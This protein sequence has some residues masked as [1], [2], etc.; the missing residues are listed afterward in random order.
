MSAPKGN[1]FAKGNNGGRPTKYKPEYC[2]Q[3]IEYFDIDAYSKETIE[4]MTEYFKDGEVKKEVEKYKYV[5]NKMPTIFRFAQKIGVNE[6][7]LVEWSKVNQE[8]SAA[9]KA[10]KEIQKEFLISLGLSGAAPSPAFIFTAKNVTDMKDKTETDITSGGNVV[11]GFNFIK[12]G[13]TTDNKT[14]TKTGKGV[15]KTS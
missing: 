5:P 8:F 13:D 15:G 6:D 10:A 14:I 1:K 3:L 9:Y 12:N 4:K 7:T 11:A 2:Q